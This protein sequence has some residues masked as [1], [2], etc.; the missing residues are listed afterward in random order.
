MTL[1]AGEFYEV[2]KT[3]VSSGM[4]DNFRLFSFGENTCFGPM[5]AW[6]PLV[7]LLL[8]MYAEHNAASPVMGLGL[9][10]GLS[11]LAPAPYWLQQKLSELHADLFRGSRMCQ[12]LQYWV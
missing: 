8:A 11:I 1:K 9:P 4:F 2:K 3:L 10:M 6:N 7:R 12:Q 5:S